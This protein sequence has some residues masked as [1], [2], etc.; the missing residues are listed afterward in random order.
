M[1]L[2][3]HILNQMHQEKLLWEMAEDTCE[4]IEQ[5]DQDPELIHR[6]ETTEI[7]YFKTYPSP[8]LLEPFS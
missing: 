2:P 7:R 5:L 3:D 8:V 1:I 4:K 6:F